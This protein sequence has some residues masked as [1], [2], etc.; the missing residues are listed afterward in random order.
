MMAVPRKTRQSTCTSIASDIAAITPARHPHTTR[1]SRRRTRAS[2]C[3]ARGAPA[4]VIASARVHDP[5][6]QAGLPLALVLLV[7]VRGRGPERRDVGLGDL[8]AVTRE[9]VECGLV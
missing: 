5:L 9:L 4:S 7:H 8:D 6:V 2:R 1:S 3:G